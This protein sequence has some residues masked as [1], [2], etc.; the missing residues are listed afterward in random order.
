MKNFD[1]AKNL[2]S[3]CKNF[4]AITQESTMETLPYLKI[5]PRCH[6]LLFM[7]VTGHEKSFAL[8]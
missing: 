6:N 8:I 1:I 3:W 5:R 7:V 4:K 2:V